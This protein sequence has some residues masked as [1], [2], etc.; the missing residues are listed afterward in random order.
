MSKIEFKYCIFILFYFIFQASEA[1]VI[2]EQY[3]KTQEMTIRIEG[4][5]TPQDLDD[6]N[7]A[8]KELSES[9]KML[10]MNSVVLKSHGG[11]TNAAIDIG[12]L[13]RARK[14]NTF[15]AS[16]SDCASACVDILI[17]GVQRY[18]F[19]NVRVHRSTFSH[20]YDK[21]DHIV[22]FINDDQKSIE[23]YV[24]SMGISMMLA[25]AMLSTEAWGIR[26]LTELEK[27]QWQVFGFDRLI[28]ET[29]FS[30]T[31]RDRHISRKEFTD[32]FKSNFDSC[33]RE[34][35]NFKQTIFDCT[36]VKSANPPSYYMQLMKWLDKKMD[37]YVRT[38]L[39]DLSLNER[40]EVLRKKI[41]D[42]RLYLR[43][44]TITEV[45]NLSPRSSQLH[46]VDT[47]SVQKL[48]ASNKWWVEDDTLLVLVSNPIDSKLKE[49]VFELSTAECDLGDGGK[50]RLL[51]LPLLANLE[52][53]NSAVY[54]G[55]LPFNYS[56]VIGKGT[57]CGVIKAAFK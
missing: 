44:T 20:D 18:A 48:E 41:R 38:D 17:S 35:R 53:Q 19:G 9:K 5:I 36:R 54:S 15:L 45:N 10:H 31:A 6:F 50:K 2:F 28:E 34:A 57:R 39:N 56:K 1:K 25:D 11:S 13:I 26:Q 40:V 42:G 27:K 51:S 49:I 29:F 4:E 16:G 52:G 12:K 3:P 14:L 24:K 46:S 23:S 8:L 55:K 33:L 47:V 7:D 21:D 37:I 30:E 32:I 43:Y 22:K